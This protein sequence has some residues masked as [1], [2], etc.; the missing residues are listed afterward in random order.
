MEDGNTAEGSA[1]PLGQITV[2]FGVEGL[3]EGSHEGNLEAGASNGSFAVN[4]HDLVVDHQTE[5][6]G[7]HI[8]PSLPP[9][10]AAR[11]KPDDR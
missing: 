6:N 10:E 9:F 3:Q 4:V 8:L 11:C 2:E 7:H 1:C 5:K